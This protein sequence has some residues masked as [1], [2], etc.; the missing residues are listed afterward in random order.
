MR[1]PLVS[2]EVAQLPFDAAMLNEL[3]DP[4][5]FVDP[6]LVAVG[7]NRAAR[8]LLGDDDLS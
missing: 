4:V 6:R 7:C 1:L 5:L 2:I 3:A 8:Q